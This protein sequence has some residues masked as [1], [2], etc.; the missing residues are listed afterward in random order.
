MGQGAAEAVAENKAADNIK[1]V[2]FDSNHKLVK[3][4]KDGAIAALLV[5]DPFGIKTGLAA[6]KGE[7]A[8]ANI[9]TGAN[10]INHENMNSPRSQELLSPKIKYGTG[11]PPIHAQQL[12]TENRFEL[13]KLI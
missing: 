2:A 7:K 8:E 4:L 5:Q 9:D 6:S 3:F 11:R 10:L 13:F 12:L 1:L